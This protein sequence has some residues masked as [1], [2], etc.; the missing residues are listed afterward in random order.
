MWNHQ[1][2]TTIFTIA[3]LLAGSDPVQALSPS[4]QGYASDAEI[5]E[6]AAL[7]VEQHTRS[8][9]T[10]EQRLVSTLIAVMKARDLQE[11]KAL[12]KHLR[13]WADFSNSDLKAIWL[14]I[15]EYS[16]LYIKKPDCNG[17]IL[18]LNVETL[19]INLVIDAC[20]LR[21]EIEQGIKRPDRATCMRVANKSIVVLTAKAYIARRFPELAK[22][23]KSKG[24]KKKV[25]PSGN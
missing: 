15:V 16:I 23:R 5:Q 3:L 4:R 13:S 24:T 2:L 6:A 18:V 22:C 20:D 9:R 21:N 19:A 12:E 25:K 10:D 17:R 8:L 11:L 14:K 7:A 1:T